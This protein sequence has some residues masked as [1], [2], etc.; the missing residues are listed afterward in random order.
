MWIIRDKPVE[1]NAGSGLL[2]GKART[3]A[4]RKTVGRPRASSKRSSRGGKFAPGKGMNRKRK[5][6]E[7]QP[8]GDKGLDH[9]PEEQSGEFDGGPIGIDQ[10]R[11]KPVKL[12]T[13]VA[14]GGGSIGD[15]E[16]GG[17]MG[18]EEISDIEA[19]WETD[20]ETGGRVFKIKS[21]NPSKRRKQGKPKKDSSEDLGAAEDI[22]WGDFI[23]VDAFSEE[24]VGTGELMTIDQLAQEARDATLLDESGSDTGKSSLNGTNAATEEQ[25]GPK[26]ALGTTADMEGKHGGIC[27]EE[28]PDPG[29]YIDISKWEA[30]GLHKA[31]LRGLKYLGFST[32]TQIQSECLP[33]ALKG[34]DIIGAAETGSGKTLAFGL[35]ILQYLLD[36]RDVNGT[37][38]PRD[39][40]VGLI[41]TPTRELAIQ[42]KDHISN[43]GKLASV[44]VAAI[45]GGMSV[46]KQERLLKM[47][48]NIVIATPGRFWDL[49]SS[50]DTYMGWLRRVRFLVLDE[51]DRMLER[52]HFR[53][54]KSIFS[55]VN[56]CADD[57]EQTTK[58]RQTFVFSATLAKDLSY[59]KLRTQ[60]KKAHNASRDP[61]SELLSEVKFQDDEPVHVDVTT[62]EA[63]SRTL[64]ELR[65]DTLTEDKDNY[66]YY[67][68]LRYPG[69]TLVFMNSID[70]IMRIVP[71]L[72]LLK[73]NVYG[74]HAKL[75]Q[76]QRLKNVDRFKA[77]PNSVLVAS[78][79]AARGLD[80]PEV[81]C[82]IHY[83]L[84][85]SG[86]I[87]VH[88]S[89]RT[90]RAKK[91]GVSIMFVSPE[92]RKVYFG[93]CKVLG[94]P[95]I[96]E[97]PV[98]LNWLSRTAERIAL[99]RDIDK[100]E[101][102]MRRVS[103][104]KSWREKSAEELGIE[105][106]SDFLPS[107]DSEDEEVRVRKQ[108][109][110]NIR[111]MKQEL[112]A[113][114]SKKLLPRGM[115]PRY[116]TSGNMRDVITRLNNVDEQNPHMPTEKAELMTSIAKR[117]VKK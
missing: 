54:L 26:G 112:N 37:L 45:V 18:L 36:H 107:S 74:L 23:P 69:R 90:A 5:R 113:L 83:Q 75:Q 17:L 44:K 116:L 4:D 10:L 38:D 25:A 105:L 51:A 99:A 88:R 82:V 70:A 33:F 53:E 76:R 47:H 41:M 60:S 34:R 109:Q 16:I 110:T 22:D 30:L 7:R 56:Q 100:E 95:Q 98:D 73:L 91:D 15:D 65:I 66:L 21:A 40:M 67:L 77:T 1:E 3:A 68:L 89:G 93:I 52:G 87:Y 6:F 61:M 35:P 86:D 72:R 39:Q 58:G 85:R 92:E 106:D 108:S 79:V 8:T 103:Y 114:L 94:K 80:I 81:D 78:D 27:L 111:A 62:K 12:P 49:F 96:P 63:V 19:D 57:D 50:S 117:V 104:E 11:W 13:S 71:I 46:Q 42:V 29:K 32:P 84:P 14:A 2:A 102:R 64:S 20:Q 24:K 48:P 101:H 59:R 97:F 115:S 31:L 55:A 28:A 43:V 9:D